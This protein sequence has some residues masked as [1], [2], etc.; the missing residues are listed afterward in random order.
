MKIK[1]KYNK[2]IITKKK[3]FDTNQVSVTHET[4]HFTFGKLGGEV[5]GGLYIKKGF[6]IPD[7]LEIDIPPTKKEEKHEPNS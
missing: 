1:A 7:V 2:L 6:P 3:D 4:H 5:S